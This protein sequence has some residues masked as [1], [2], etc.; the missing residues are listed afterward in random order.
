MARLDL[1][2]ARAARAEAACE[3]HVVVFGG[4]EFVLPVEMPAEVAF[5]FADNDPEAALTVLLGDQWPAFWAKQPTVEDMAELGSGIAAAYGFA[6]PGESPASGLP[7][8]S[9]SRRSRPTSP[10]TTASTFARPASGNGHSGPG[11]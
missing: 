7:S 5:R 1:D 3:Q 6:S 8:Q 9:F 2:A 10:G 4:E 11:A